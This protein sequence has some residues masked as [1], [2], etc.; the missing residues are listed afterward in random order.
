[1]GYERL[2]RRKNNRMKVRDN[3]NIK[4]VELNS[5][6][7]EPNNQEQQLVAS[8]NLEAGTATQFW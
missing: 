2:V 7:N 3:R 6:V 8:Q 4:T 5:D 1:M